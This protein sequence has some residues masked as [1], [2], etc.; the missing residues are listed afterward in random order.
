M[1]PIVQVAIITVAST[2]LSKGI[3]HV[4]K[5]RAARQ[6]QESLSE[7]SF[8]DNLMRRVETLEK[9]NTELLKDQGELKA[10]VAELQVELARY[11]ECPSV[12]CPLRSHSVN[13]VPKSP[14]SL[15]PIR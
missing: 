10:K 4:V 1:D 6:K 15:L 12:A 11:R 14:A 9:L 8:L 2:V 13:V 7:E 5:A 3:E